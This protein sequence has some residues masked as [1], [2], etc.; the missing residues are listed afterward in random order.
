MS[1]SSVPVQTGGA[2]VLA[3]AAAKTGGSAA[4]HAVAELPAT[5]IRS[6]RA[7]FLAGATMIGVGAIL[8][9]RGRTLD[10]SAGSDLN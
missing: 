6:I 9:R 3:A 1:V 4:V 10:L 7:L 8:I 5:G 2:A